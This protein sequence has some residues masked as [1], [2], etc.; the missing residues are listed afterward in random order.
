M[1][2][3]IVGLIAAVAL[4]AAIGGSTLAVSK[5]QS[6]YVTTDTACYG[7]LQVNQMGDLSDAHV[8]LKSVTISQIDNDLV[9]TL[10]QGGVQVDSGWFDYECTLN[11]KYKLADLEGLSYSGSGTFTLKVD[12]NSGTNYSG[13]SFSVD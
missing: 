11:N 12:W 6:A 3:R 1:N 2:P 5:A 13:D 9:W 8:Y 7:D 4:V 10:W